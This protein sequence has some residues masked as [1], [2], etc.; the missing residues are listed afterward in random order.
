MAGGY[1]TR[2]WPITKTRAKPL[3]PLGSKK[4]I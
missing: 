3:L 2:L 4:I 1:A